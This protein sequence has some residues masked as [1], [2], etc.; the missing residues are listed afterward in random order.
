MADYTDQIAVDLSIESNAHSVAS[1]GDHEPIDIMVATIPVAPP[2]P[3]TEAPIISNMSP[4]AGSELSANDAIEF[5]VTDNSGAFARI[6][7]VAYFPETGDQ[8][9]IFD[10]ASFVGRYTGISS[11][12]P[13]T[14]GFRYTVARSGGWQYAPTIR[15]FP[16]DAAGNQ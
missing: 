15:I 13:I 6:F 14:L 16:I 1:A 10:G 9:V 3:D 5:D 4:G 8:D 11:R 12:V 2:T 7:V